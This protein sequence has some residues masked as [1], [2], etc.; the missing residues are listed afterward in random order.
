MDILPFPVERIIQ[1]LDVPDCDC[2]PCFWGEYRDAQGRVQRV[3][4][5]RKRSTARQAFVEFLKEQTCLDHKGKP[6]NLFKINKQNRSMEL[7]LR[8]PTCEHV[9]SAEHNLEV[10]EWAKLLKQA[11]QEE[12][13]DR[14]L[15]P[16]ITVE[17]NQDERQEILAWRR[18]N[19]FAL[20]HPD[21]VTA[22]DVPE[23]DGIDR[24]NQ[25]N[26]NGSDEELELS[27]RKVG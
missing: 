3:Q 25:R 6:S 13:A 18:R 17:L 12:Y 19:K 7:I 11:D 21:D 4:L 8:Y 23:I 16:H 10:S 9:L 15:P 27:V 24:H 5:C 14:P 26:R 2:P 1:A 22:N 20:F